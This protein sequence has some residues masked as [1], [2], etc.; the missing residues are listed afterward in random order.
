MTSL[1]KLEKHMIYALNHIDDALAILENLEYT[2]EYAE[3]INAIRQIMTG[4]WNLCGSF[5]NECRI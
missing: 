2:E 3:K 5:I 4:T 1:K